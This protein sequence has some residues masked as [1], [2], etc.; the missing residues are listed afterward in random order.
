MSRWTSLLLSVAVSAAPLPA[1]AA[2]PM[3]KL[4]RDVAQEQERG[5][6]EDAAKRAAEA[7]RRSDLRTADRHHLAGLARESYELAFEHSG[8]PQ[9]LCQL[10]VL[11]S[12]MSALA[13]DDAEREGTR[14]AQVDVDTRLREAVASGAAVPCVVP[15]V[16]S[17]VAAGAPPQADPAAAEAEPAPGAVAPISSQGSQPRMNADASPVAPA[18]SR[19]SLAQ[20]AVGSSLFV[21]SAGLAAGAVALFLARE[22]EEHR[23]AALV[24]L[25]EA[26]ERPATAEEYSRAQAAN[27]RYRRFHGSALTVATLAGISLVTAVLLIVVPAKTRPGSQARVRPTATGISVAF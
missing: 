15:P 2:D 26:E 5:R 3:G 4:L 9:H 23:I 8:D 14:A 11:L 1:S 16:R 27:A 13:A 7:S 19:R 17:G 18:R 10:R 6:F 24:A 21:V 25:T 20:L 12:E 22:R